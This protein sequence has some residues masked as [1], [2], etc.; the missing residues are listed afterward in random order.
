M[1]QIRLDRGTGAYQLHHSRPLDIV[2]DDPL[3]VSVNGMH[4]G[5][6][7]A[8]V[9]QPLIVPQLGLDLVAEGIVI[10][11]FVM[12]LLDHRLLS[13]AFRKIGIAALAFTQQANDPV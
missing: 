8:S 10:A 12:D 7:D 13:I 9:L 5:Y 2:L 3:G 4:P 1:G 6:T 11:R